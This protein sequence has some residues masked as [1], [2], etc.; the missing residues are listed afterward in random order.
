MSLVDRGI[1]VGNLSKRINSLL[2]AQLIDE[3]ISAEQR[4]IQRDWEPAEL[5]GGQF[6]EIAARIWYAEDSQNLNLTKSLDDCLK[7]IEYGMSREDRLE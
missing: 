7:Y 3:F 2:A 1:L 4:F 5:D 6:A